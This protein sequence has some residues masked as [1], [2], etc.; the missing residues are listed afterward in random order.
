LISR[1]SERL[2][3]KAPV[4]ALVEAKND[5]LQSGLGQCMAEMIAAQIFN[6]QYANL[7]D[8]FLLSMA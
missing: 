5:N 3:I 1:S 2:T 7:I 4:I 8:Q 6:R